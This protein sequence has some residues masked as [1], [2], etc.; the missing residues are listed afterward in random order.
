MKFGGHRTKYRCPAH[1]EIGEDQVL[2]LFED[3]ETKWVRCHKCYYAFISNQ[4]PE[5]TEIK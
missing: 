1:G 5:I 3:G 4:L 2:A